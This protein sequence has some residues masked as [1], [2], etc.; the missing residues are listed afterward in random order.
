[1]SGELPLHEDLRSFDKT[2]GQSFTIWREENELVPLGFLLPLVVVV[3]P[4][5]L[6]RDAELGDGGAVGALTG[7]IVAQVAQDCDLVEFGIFLS[8]LPLFSWA[9]KVQ[10]QAPQ[11][12]GFDRFVWVRKEFV[13]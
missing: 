5:F 1:V 13:T 10:R 6:G 12:F 11:W 9:E 7:G 8:F 3:L 2:A 4:R